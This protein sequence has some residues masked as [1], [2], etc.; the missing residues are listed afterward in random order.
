MELVNKEDR[1]AALAKY[2]EEK[3]FYLKEQ[4]ASLKKEQASLD[5]MTGVFNQELAITEEKYGKVDSIKNKISLSEALKQI[6]EL[7]TKNEN[8]KQQLD[9]AQQEINKLTIE[10]NSLQNCVISKMSDSNSSS[11]INKGASAASQNVQAKPSESSKSIQNGSQKKQFANKAQPNIQVEPE[12]HSS[13]R[14]IRP[15]KG[16]ERYWR[17]KYGWK[18]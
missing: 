11:N 16:F 18:D 4:I 12:A 9:N 5:S 2:N 7:S 15:R 3:E 13:R 10:K 14:L 17:M 6:Q 8:Q 1:L